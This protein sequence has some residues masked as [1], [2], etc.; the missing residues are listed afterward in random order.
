MLVLCVCTGGSN[1]DTFRRLGVPID[2]KADGDS[3]WFKILVRTDP[4][5]HR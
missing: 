3:S 2:R 4:L 1:A 5:T